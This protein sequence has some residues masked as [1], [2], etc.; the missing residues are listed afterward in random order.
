MKNEKFIKVVNHDI[1]INTRYIVKL[2]FD[3]FAT[4]GEAVMCYGNEWERKTVYR[5]DVEH[6]I[7]K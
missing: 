1:Y 7:T 2:E 6:L 5:K 3:D 4:I